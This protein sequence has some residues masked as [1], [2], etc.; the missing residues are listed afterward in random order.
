MPFTD[1]DVADLKAIVKQKQDSPIM[2]FLKDSKEYKRQ[3]GDG[4]R[5]DTPAEE[6]KEPLGGDTPLHTGDKKRNPDAYKQGG[7]VK[8]FAKGGKIDGVAQRGKTRGRI[9]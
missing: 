4:D 9:V 5:R 8:T 3:Y 7:K 1:K 6:P 2:S